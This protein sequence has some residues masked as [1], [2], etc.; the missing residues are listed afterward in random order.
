VVLVDW[1][2]ARRV[3]N[4]GTLAF[5]GVREAVRNS[6]FSLEAVDNDVLNTLIPRLATARVA[7]RVGIFA[8]KEAAKAR[9]R[10]MATIASQLGGIQNVADI[11]EVFATENRVVPH[12]LRSPGATDAAEILSNE[13]NYD[14]PCPEDGIWAAVLIAGRSGTRSELFIPRSVY[15]DH[16]I[17]DVEGQFSGLSGP[18][19]IMAVGAAFDGD[20]RKGIATRGR[21]NQASTRMLGNAYATPYEIELGNL[22]H[23]TLLRGNAGYNYR[24]YVAK[25]Q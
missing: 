24:V 13:Q 10:C 8:P 9:Q 18:R 17:D 23:G 3:C 6:P 11:T 15:R 5:A 12:V 22:P 21:V 1:L 4:D 2:S 7:A 14:I 20:E 16:A 19:I 25:P